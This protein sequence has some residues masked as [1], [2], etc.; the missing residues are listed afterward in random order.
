MNSIEKNKSILNI[1]NDNNN[2]NINNNIIIPNINIFNKLINQNN[3]NS[4]PS[5]RDIYKDNLTKMNENI[6]LNMNK[7]NPNLRNNL[8][9]N[10]NLTEVSFSPLYLNNKSQRMTNLYGNENENDANDEDF[11]KEEDKDKSLL[12]NDF[13]N[14]KLICNFMKKEK[15][16]K[17]FEKLE[18]NEK[19]VNN[20]E[21]NSKKNNNIF[22][23]YV[24][25][26]EK[27]QNIKGIKNNINKKNLNIDD[28]DSG[29][30]DE[31][32]KNLLNKLNN[33]II[34]KSDSETSEKEEKSSEIEIKNQLKEVCFKFVL[35]EK[36][37]S[38]LIQEKA[39]NINQ[40][41]TS[42]N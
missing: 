20:K 4:F 8:N 36:E 37:Y 26:I 7:T 32:I 39:K 33:N 29:I 22:K 9:L 11:E 2:L 12:D 17:S 24:D 3:I 42:K 21:I 30:L 35:N 27:K 5:N 40:L 38:L 31:K 25:N 23:D 18:K 14:N 10:N 13:S 34:L 6:N 15:E 1:N 41:I 19:E 16:L 28:F